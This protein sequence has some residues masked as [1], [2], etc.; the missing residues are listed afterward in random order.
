M[1]SRAEQHIFRQSAPGVRDAA[2]Q[3]QERDTRL[4]D[5]GGVT[6]GDEKTAPAQTQ[7]ED[8]RTGAI[9]EEGKGPAVVVATMVLWKS[10]MLAP[11]VI[12]LNA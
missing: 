4:Y 10:H 2:E 12:L 1:T 7:E 3:G 9:G 5:R 6:G 8:R 11:P